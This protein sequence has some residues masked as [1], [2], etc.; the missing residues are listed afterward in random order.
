MNNMK[1]L[2]EEENSNLSK[3]REKMKALFLEVVRLG[4]NQER[5]TTNINGVNSALEDKIRMLESKIS[6]GE[7]VTS[8]IAIRGDKNIS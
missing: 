6:N 7:R 3:E 4:E 5:Q 8:Q 1:G 2:I